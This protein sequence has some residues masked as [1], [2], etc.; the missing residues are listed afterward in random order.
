MIEKRRWARVSCEWEAVFSSIT[1]KPEIRSSTT[2]DL[3]EGGVRFRTSDFVAV[4]DRIRFTIRPPRG[5][6]LDTVLSTVW[7]REIPNLSLYEVGGSFEDISADAR[8]ALRAWTDQKQAVL[9]T[10]V[11]EASF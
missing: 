1:R 4:G 3:S 11:P 10:R 5:A 8:L 2:L 6:A 9:I 7:V